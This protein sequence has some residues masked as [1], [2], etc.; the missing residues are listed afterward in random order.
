[1]EVK[2]TVSGSLL[3]R[4]LISRFVGFSAPWA[5]TVREFPKAVQKQDVFLRWQR[6]PS[7]HD[8]S[9]LAAIIVRHSLGLILIIEY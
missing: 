4:D 2:I 6:F 3:S 7:L 8:H 5:W 9:Y 1:M